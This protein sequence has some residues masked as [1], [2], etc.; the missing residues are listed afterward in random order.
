MA[1]IN[2]LE[3]INLERNSKHTE[4]K[5]TYSVVESEGEKFLQI[6]TYGSVTRQFPGKKSQSL[7]FTPEALVQLKSIIDSEL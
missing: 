3:K 5:G 1:I 7:R 4:V 6:D 2:K